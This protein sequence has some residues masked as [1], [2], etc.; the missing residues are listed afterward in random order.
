MKKHL[1]VATL[2]F[3][4]MAL[5]AQEPFAVSSGDFA[6]YNESGERLALDENAARTATNGWVIQ[7][8]DRPVTIQTPVGTIELAANATLV[9][10][11]LSETRPSLYL[12]DGKASFSTARDFTGRLTV[13]TPVSRY[14][15]TG[16]SGMQITT[17]SDEESI[18]MF[19]GSAQSVNGLTHKATQVK[20]MEKLDQK[21]GQ[22]TLLEAE[23]MDAWERSLAR[24]PD[25]PAFG[26]VVVTPYRGPVPSQPQSLTVFRLPAAPSGLSVQVLE[27][28]PAPGRISVSSEAAG[29]DAFIPAPTPSQ[30]RDDMATP[31]HDEPA[32]QPKK[33][34]DTRMGVVVSYEYDRAGKHFYTNED[35]RI[36][37]NL[38]QFDVK[39][40]F[41]SK[42][43]GLKLDL[44]VQTLNY[45]DWDNGWSSNLTHFDSD[46]W[47]ETTSSIMGYID[48]FHLGSKSGHLWMAV[49]KD[50]LNEEGKIMTGYHA[51]QPDWKNLS[52]GMR[53]GSVRINGT[54]DD[55]ELH[56]MR[57]EERSLSGWQY[58]NLSLSLVDD[59]LSFFSFGAVYAVHG[60][61]AAAFL[62]DAHTYSSVSYPYAEINIPFLGNKRKYHLNLLG[63]AAT[64]LPVSPDMNFDYIYDSDESS[65][66]NFLLTGGLSF[67]TKAWDIQLIAG[68]HKGFINPYVRSPFV[69]AAGMNYLQYTSDMDARLQATYKGRFFSF[70]ASYTL[71]FDFD[72]DDKIARFSSDVGTGLHAD[73]LSIGF[74][75]QLKGFT[76]SAGYEVYGLNDMHGLDDADDLS[77][78][79]KAS[80]AYDWSFLHLEGGVKRNIDSSTSPLVGYALCELD[81]H[82]G[83]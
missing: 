57:E 55:V 23:D 15:A 76:L 62:T 79:L 44:A 35:D 32:A 71:P 61:R 37:K 60:D 43:F 49:D 16:Y 28:A 52:L 41:E 40:Y 48:S 51:V 50:P 66:D 65:F 59:D 81:F 56:H 26:S 8:Q 83:F 75:A 38:H 36:S 46:G 63:S 42:Y 54:F 68:H 33:A 78:M 45:D 27:I 77:T 72:E 18:S 1:L 6:L 5:P 10:G 22:I 31:R 53:F 12:V 82:K 19:V 2:F 58:G 39:P 21:T 47:K 25:A 67:G 24:I 29:D 3:A 74:S 11:D 7:T 73:M 9:T 80:L 20:A 14:R 64:Y 4:A 34:S 17:T 70:G 30:L 69:R 13:S